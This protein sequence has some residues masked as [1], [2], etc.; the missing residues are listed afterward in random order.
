MTVELEPETIIKNINNLCAELR[1]WTHAI[2]WLLQKN[3]PDSLRLSLL[4]E[5]LQMVN[6]EIQSEIS[7]LLRCL[8]EGYKGE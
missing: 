3:H 2:E 1:D 8:Q 6:E 5:S 7:A 4:S